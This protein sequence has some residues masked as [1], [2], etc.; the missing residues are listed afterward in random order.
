MGTSGDVNQII[1]F[2][3]TEGVLPGKFMKGFIH[4]LEVP[5]ICQFLD[6]QSHLCIQTTALDVC[7]YAPCRILV[8]LLM[9]Q[10]KSGN[11]EILMSAE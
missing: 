2:V 3:G 4:L 9:Y 6:G 5:G 11:G 8:H 1:L 7:G 10:F